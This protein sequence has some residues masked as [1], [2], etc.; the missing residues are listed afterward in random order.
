[1]TK[2]RHG[3]QNSKL[4][5]K[6]NEQAEAVELE[7]MLNINPEAVYN[8]LSVNEPSFVRQYAP[9]PLQ[10]IYTDNNTIQK[11]APKPSAPEMVLSS[12]TQSSNTNILDKTNTSKQNKSNPYKCLGPLFFNKINVAKKKTNKLNLKICPHYKT[13]TQKKNKNWL[14]FLGILHKIKQTNKETKISSSF[15]DNV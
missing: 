6:Q 15:F 13:L 10:T 14:K 1:M 9:L 3:I 4:F 7:N 11:Y 8:S 12:N 2:V 5:T